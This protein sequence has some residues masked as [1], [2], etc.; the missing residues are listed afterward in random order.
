MA[1]RRLVRDAKRSA[2]DLKAARDRVDAAKRNLGERGPPWWTD[3]AP[4]YNRHM[5]QNTPYAGWFA[6]L[7]G[8]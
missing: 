7:P 8:P 6:T 2:G 3:G 4:D 1:A 5:V